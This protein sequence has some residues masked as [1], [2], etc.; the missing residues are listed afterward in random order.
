MDRIDMGAARQYMVSPPLV[1]ELPARICIGLGGQRCGSSWLHLQLSRHASIGAPNGV[2]EVHFFDRNFDRGPAWYA[3]H[4]RPKTNALWWDSTPYYLYDPQVSARIN[5]IVRDPIFVVLLRDPASRSLSH[6][7]RY[8]AN[9]GQRMGLEKAVSRKPS[10]LAFSKYSQFLKPYFDLFGPERIF[11]GMY[12]DI[13]TRPQALLTD[14]LRFLD[15][16]PM[17]LADAV[18]SERV[19]AGVAPRHGALHAVTETSKRWMRLH[20]LGHVVSFGRAMG[21]R[22]TASQAIADPMP[23][24]QPEARRLLEDIRHREIR[25]LQTLGLPRPNWDQAVPHVA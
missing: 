17:T 12:E 13:E 6:Y 7:R 5:S 19:N 18:L 24:L 25:A 21:L 11:V 15:L 2:K 8:L 1:A 4:F 23:A 14:I 22:P 16:P 10:I 3:G 20:G 9:T